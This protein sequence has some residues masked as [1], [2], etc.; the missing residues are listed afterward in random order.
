MPGVMQTR[1]TTVC[2]ILLMLGF[3]ASAAY[4]SDE[5]QHRPYPHHHLSF[6]VGGNYERDSEGH[7]EN[8]HALGVI[9]EYQFREKWGIGAAIEE[10]YSDNHRRARAYAIPVSYHLNE[11]WRFFAGPG[12]ETGDE[13]NFF[14]RVGVSREFEFSERWTASP[15]FLVDFIESGAKTYVLGFA[16]GYVF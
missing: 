9:Y 2:A 15:E 4:A 13:D 3:F 12:A 11:K 10:L 16:I 6:F 14:V 8:G 1:R 7:E 5:E